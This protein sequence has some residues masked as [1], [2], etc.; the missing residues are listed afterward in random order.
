MMQK[1]KDDFSKTIFGMSASEAWEKRIC[2]SCGEPVSEENLR[3]SKEIAE[4]QI[5]GLCG[6][7]WDHIFGDGE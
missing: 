1:L 2:V 7:C 5:S 4:Y 6:H 3:D